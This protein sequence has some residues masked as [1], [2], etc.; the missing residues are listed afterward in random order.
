M[1][2]GLISLPPAPASPPESSVETDGWYPAVD[3]NDVRARMRIG[4]IVT[5]AR[6]RGAIVGAMLTV[7]RELDAWAKRQSDAGYAS[8]EEVPAPTIDFESRLVMA[9]RRAIDHHVMAELAETHRDIGATEN[10]ALRSEEVALTADEYRRTA[11]HAV[12]DV[13]GVPRTSIGLI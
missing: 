6:L 1:A 10:G 11:T 2:N 4:T 9:W 7:E 13:L 12:R 5:D 3:V 8:L